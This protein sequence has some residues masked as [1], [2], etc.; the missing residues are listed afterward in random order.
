[1]SV[2]VDLPYKRNLTWQH[3]DGITITHWPDDLTLS[4]HREAGRGGMG[5]IY[6][7]EDTKLHRFV[8]LKFLPEEFAPDL[9]VLSR[10]EREAQAASAL[11][12]PNI[13]S[14]YEIGERN[15][16]PFIAM[17][18]LEGHTLKYGIDGQPLTLEQVLQLGL[19]I[20]DA[21][22][23]AHAKGIVHRDI[24]PA[25]IFVTERGHTKILDFGLA[26]VVPVGST[27][28]VSQMPTVTAEELLTSPGTTM[29]TMAHMSP[30][31]A[32]G[33]EL[34]ARTDL[35]S[36]G[37]VLYEMATGLMAFPGNTAA[38]VHEAIL[39]RA[40]V[41]VAR[42]KPELPPKLEEVI[43]KAL[44]KER[45]LRYQSAADIRTDLQR[46]KRHT[47][48]GRNV[49][50]GLVPG[51]VPV[52]RE[53]RETALLRKTWIAALSAGALATLLAIL[54]AFGSSIC[55]AG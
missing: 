36:F 13:C 31:Q 39:N 10:F 25:N 20:A 40:P 41:P 16:Q 32:W 23:S 8:A 6:K 49:V 22:D 33:E 21:L 9:Q 48:S 3:N 15:G 54:F 26:K 1:L 43:N 37:A 17:E 14:I 46:L 19:E 51:R 47:E 55:A 4:R 52:Q 44:E 5:V 11:N 34:D 50:T 28:G 7:A 53:Q 35:F 42:V 27:V 24:K 12:H 2:L 38:I 29:G 45:K 30:E 18:F